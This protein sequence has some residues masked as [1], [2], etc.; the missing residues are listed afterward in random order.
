VVPQVDSE[1]EH[2][3]PGNV[4][5][6]E[7]EEP[8]STAEA[9]QSSIDDMIGELSLGKDSVSPK[10]AS[11]KAQQVAGDSDD[12]DAPKFVTLAK[13][14]KEVEESACCSGR[15]CSIASAEGARRRRLGGS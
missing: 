4:S 8:F 15:F 5:R 10:Q 14:D 11:P 12:D 7:Q 3:G 2:V 13:H 6:D 9:K 1:D